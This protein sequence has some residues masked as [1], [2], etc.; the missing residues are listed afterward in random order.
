MRP[1]RYKLEGGFSKQDM[2]KM[3]EGALRLIRK[4]GLKVPHESIRRLI[5]EIDGVEIRDDNVTF[6]A[7]LVEKARVAQ[8]YSDWPPDLGPENPNV[9]AGAYIKN[10]LDPETNKIRPALIAGPG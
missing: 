7:E 8:D 10:V 9:I 1:I 6:N 5:A 2:D 3:W 4:V